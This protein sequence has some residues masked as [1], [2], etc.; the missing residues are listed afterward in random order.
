M[1]LSARPRKSRRRGKPGPVV[2]LRAD[3]D[4]LPVTEEVDGAFASKV[5]AAW[6]GRD[7]GAMRASSKDGI[8][9]SILLA[10]TQCLD[11]YRTDGNR[12]HLIP[13]EVRG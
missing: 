13:R 3:T 11:G 9:R 6:N 2:A 1:P 12:P 7:V 5:K 10:T 8:A 4:A